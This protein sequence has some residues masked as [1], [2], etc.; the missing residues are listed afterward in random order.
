MT[1]NTRT[2]SRTV[3]TLSF[4][5]NGEDREV[6]LMFVPQDYPEPF[7][8][9]VGDK[10][11]VAY[12]VHDDD[13]AN[14]MTNNDG[15]GELITGNEGVITDG[16]PWS[17]LGLLGSPYRGNLEKDFECDGVYD[18]AVELMTPELLE[19]EDFL[20]FCIEH[21]ENDTGV[22]NKRD[23]L[24]ECIAEIDWSRYGMTIPCWLESICERAQ[25]QAWDE[26]QEQGKIGTYLAVPVCYCD[27]VH[28]PGT[29]QI[30]TTYIDDC[31]AV[32]IPTPCDIDNIKAQCWPEGVE[33]TWH[34]AAGSQ[35]DPLH[36]V[37]TFKGEVVFDTPKWADAQKFIDERYGL[38][39]DKDLYKVAEKYAQGCLEEYEKWCNGDCYGCVCEVFE[40]QDGDWVQIS[41]DACWGFI[42]Y[43]YAKQTIE[44]EFFK[45]NFEAIKEKACEAA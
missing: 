25:E 22:D 13:C 2:F 6:E 9:V 34:G 24:L 45:P 26:L 4:E 39:T 8:E 11:V 33:I 42:G 38:P 23:F 40:C 28:G 18:K 16:N 21:F 12:L 27:S 17:H 10:L 35:T 43:D 32:W 1:I 41:E 5:H 37:V 3:S 44:E 15:M 7:V 29:T 36:A 31:N 14:P 19:D 20:E 30:Y